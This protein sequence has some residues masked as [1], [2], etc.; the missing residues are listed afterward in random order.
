MVVRL[1]TNLVTL[2]TEIGAFAA[3]LIALAWFKTQAL[4]FSNIGPAD[5]IDRLTPL[6]LTAVFIERSVEVLISPW[7]D[8]EAN[9]YATAIKTAE[10]A[11]VPDHAAAAHKLRNV[12]SA[13]DTL[14]AYTG[15]TQRYAFLAGL[16]LGLIASLAGVSALTP[17]LA[18]DAL[19]NLPALQHALFAGFDIVL[20]AAL[21]A[22]GADGLHS[23]ISAFTSFFSATAKRVSNPS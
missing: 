23:V 10:A 12:A 21:L 13:T 22:G 3:A 6:L 9:K 7:R 2:L 4:A 18:S 20:T 14:T 19:K 5:V 1:N 11:P 15:A 8:P 17:F 16:T